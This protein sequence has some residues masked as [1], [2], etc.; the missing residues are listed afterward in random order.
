MKRFLFFAAA[1]ALAACGQAPTEREQARI[2]PAPGPITTTPTAPVAGLSS[3]EFAQRVANSNAFGIE[4][5]R[6]AAQQAKRADVKAFARTVASER[7]GA[8]RQLA[9]I[10]PQVQVTVPEP[11]LEPEQQANLNTLRSAPSTEF[12]DAYLDQQVAEQRQTVRTFEEF[13]STAPESPLREW[14][15]RRLPQLQQQLARAEALEQAT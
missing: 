9:Q 12:D 13:V 4:T 15:Q 14:A 1:L 11:I 6:I 2:E 5:S 3:A 7:E 8:A 10:A